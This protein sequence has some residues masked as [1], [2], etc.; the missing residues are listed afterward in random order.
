MKDFFGVNLK[1]GDTVAFTKKDSQK[2]FLGKAEKLYEDEKT[3]GSIAILW[4]D[5]TLD[6]FVDGVR[7]PSTYCTFANRVIKKSRK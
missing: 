4:M 5:E 7:Q 6:H 2:L 3:G 1:V